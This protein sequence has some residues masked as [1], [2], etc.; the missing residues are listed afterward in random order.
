MTIALGTE[1]NAEDEPKLDHHLADKILGKNHPCYLVYTIIQPSKSL[2][3]PTTN[4]NRLKISNLQKKT[5]G[6]LNNFIFDII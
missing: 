2:T 3:Y 5:K 4:R 1:V 6:L